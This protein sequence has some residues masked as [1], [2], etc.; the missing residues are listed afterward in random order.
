M[1]LSLYLRRRKLKFTELVKSGKWKDVE[2]FEAWV[3]KMGLDVDFEVS[4]FDK[5]DQ[6]LPPKS[7]HMVKI[8]ESVETNIS[9]TP[10]WRS[11]P[12]E[13]LPEVEE[14]AQDDEEDED[15]FNPLTIV[16]S[17]KLRSSELKK[18]KVSALKDI[19]VEKG[20]DYSGLKKDQL[21][22]KILDEEV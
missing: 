14:D 11:A 21:V 20:I 5:P 7:N 17:R 3:N 12:K 19:L 18:M 9:D 8:D 22:E 4:V 16:E 1:K 13:K 6:P 2:D 10:L 15:P